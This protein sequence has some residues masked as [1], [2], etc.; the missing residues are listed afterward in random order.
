MSTCTQIHS[1][2]ERKMSKT[3]GC[4]FSSDEQDIPQGRFTSA[5]IS[6][7]RCSEIDEGIFIWKSGIS[8]KLRE[9]S[10]RQRLFRRPSRIYRKVIYDRGYIRSW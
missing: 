7:P 9:R 5:D 3:V 6:A 1:G 10:S 4:A 8:I 2:S